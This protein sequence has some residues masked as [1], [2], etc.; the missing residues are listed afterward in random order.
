MSTHLQK[1]AASRGS[2]LY[3]ITQP[4]EDDIDYYSMI[5][6]IPSHRE[7]AFIAAQQSGNLNP[8]EYGKLLHY[9]AGELSA[10]DAQKLIEIQ[11]P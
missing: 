4:G 1:I 11:G 3:L 8:L 9:S 6:A 2:G 10:Q 5:L 7:K